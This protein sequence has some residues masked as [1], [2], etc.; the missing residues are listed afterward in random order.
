MTG[1]GE[2]A[3]PHA[4]A[5][6]RTLP[7]RPACSREMVMSTSRLELQQEGQQALDGK[8][9]D[10]AAQQSRDLRLVDADDILGLSL[11]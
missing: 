3:G 10:A 2:R 7:S 5:F 9:G 6:T 11:G 4:A 8:S 1:C